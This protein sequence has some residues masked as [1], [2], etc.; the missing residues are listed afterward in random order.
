MLLSLT[1]LSPLLGAMLAQ[2]TLS[3]LQDRQMRRRGL[4]REA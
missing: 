2:L 1:V 3:R 4:K